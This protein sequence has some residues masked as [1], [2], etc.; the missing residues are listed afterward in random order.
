[1]PH[2]PRS[3]LRSPAISDSLFVFS[4]DVGASVPQPISH[5]LLDPSIHEAVAADGQPRSARYL[6]TYDAGSTAETVQKLYRDGNAV[7]SVPIEAWP[8]EEQALAARDAERQKHAALNQQLRTAAA[9]QRGKDARQLT[10]PEMRDIMAL[11]MDERGLL[12]ADG[13]IV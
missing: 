4:C 3:R 10:F 6:T 1:M 7:R 13:K 2:L 5:M 12:D 11:W 8:T 9:A